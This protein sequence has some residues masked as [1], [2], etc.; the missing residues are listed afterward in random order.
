MGGDEFAVLLPF[1]GQDGAE[2]FANSLIERLTSHRFQFGG[3][4]YRIS[5]SMGI[6]LMPEHGE[7]VGELIINADT[8]MYEAKK[9]G[10]GCWRCFSPLAEADCPAEQSKIC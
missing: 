6:A 8:A 3:R 5:I 9:A 1:T 7:N 2:V 4:E 10:R